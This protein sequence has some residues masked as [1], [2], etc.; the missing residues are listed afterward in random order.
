MV[1]AGR[2]TVLLSDGVDPSDVARLAGRLAEIKGT[3][4]GRIY[5]NERCNFFT[6][7]NESNPADLIF[8]GSLDEDP[9]F[10]PPD[11]F[12]E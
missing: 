5:I 10:Q 3:N 8:L 6:N 2:R 12:S 1:M 7:M 11:D 9:W 4:G